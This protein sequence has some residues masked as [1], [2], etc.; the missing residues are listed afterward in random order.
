M[1]LRYCGW[2]EY[3]ARVFAEAG[4]FAGWAWLLIAAPWFHHLPAVPRVLV[5]TTCA[6]SGALTV[7]SLRLRRRRG[8][9]RRAV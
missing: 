1:K 8:S 7:A 3:A 5:I 4:F 6:V 2:P 9:E